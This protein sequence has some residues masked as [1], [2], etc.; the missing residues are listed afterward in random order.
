MENSFRFY[1]NTACKFF[2]CHKVENDEDFNCMFCYC[3]LYLMEDCKGNPKFTNGIKDCSNCLVPHR[4]SGYDHINNMLREEIFVKAAERE[5]AR[6]EKL[7]EE[8][9]K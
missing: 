8:K 7:K 5:I 3:P 4:P 1:R 6:L 2:P 9:N